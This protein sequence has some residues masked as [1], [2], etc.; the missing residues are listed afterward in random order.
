MM[1]QCFW[2]EAQRFI[3]LCLMLTRQGDGVG[4]CKDWGVLLTRIFRQRQRQWLEKTQ[5]Q[6]QGVDFGFC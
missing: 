5:H 4:G 2:R 1:K 6:T 3:A